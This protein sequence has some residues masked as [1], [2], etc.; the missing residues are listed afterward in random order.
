MLN[1]HI[2]KIQ[3]YCNETSLSDNWESQMQI[4]KDFQQE[5]ITVYM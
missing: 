4:Y 3:K 5:E 1:C 2:S